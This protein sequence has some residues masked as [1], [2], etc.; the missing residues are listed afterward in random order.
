M[1][2]DAQRLLLQSEQSNSHDGI[3]LREIVTPSSA[4][5]RG[6]PPAK[7]RKRGR[8]N[9]QDSPT[10]TITT[11]SMKISTVGMAMSGK[12]PFMKF[13][14]YR[15]HMGS[16]VPRGQFTNAFARQFLQGTEE[17]EEGEGGSAAATTD[18]KAMGNDV[19]AN[20]KLRTLFVAN[21]P[22]VTMDDVSDC[23]VEMMSCFGDVEAV[24][25][26]VR[27]TITFYFL[28]AQSNHLLCMI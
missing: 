15:R 1:D 11:D 13:S 26:G 14:Y 21:P 10:T 19:I 2:D 9:R 25:T 8:K 23:V 28:I 18:V 27:R 6:E 12:N 7:R 16:V 20:K 3:F 22:F 24:H 4:P 17:E 5:V